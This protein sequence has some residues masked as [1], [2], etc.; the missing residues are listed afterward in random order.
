MQR[1]PCLEGCLPDTQ[2]GTC[3]NAY[4]PLTTCLTQTCGA[5]CTTTIAIDASTD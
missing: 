3:P 2:T 5:Q 4:G 1:P